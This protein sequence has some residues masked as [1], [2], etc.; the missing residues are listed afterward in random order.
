M[1]DQNIFSGPPNWCKF[2]VA[3]KQGWINPTTG[4]IL[5]SIGNYFTLRP[6]YIAYNSGNNVVSYVPG[7]LDFSNPLNSI[8]YLL[9]LG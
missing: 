2:A 5:I 9:M 4:E 6:E 3:D 7:S 8:N 1:S